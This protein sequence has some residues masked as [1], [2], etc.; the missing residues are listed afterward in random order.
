ML[1]DGSR[2]RLGDRVAAGWADEIVNPKGRLDEL[3]VKAGQR[4][5]ILNLDDP[6]F[7]AELAMRAPPVSAGAGDLDILFY[8]AD[9]GAELARLPDLI[10][11]LAGRGVLWIVS[12][13]GKAATL[14]DTDIMAAARAAGLVDSKVCSFSE[15]CT[16][17]RFT[18]RR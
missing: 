1:V 3:G 18:R 9:S 8:G 4:T 7:A 12:H 5:A 6:D 16:A 15:T 14:K 2:F 17:L 13:K 10:H 11:E